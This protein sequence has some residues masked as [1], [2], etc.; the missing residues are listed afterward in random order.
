MKTLLFTS[1][2]RNNEKYIP[3]MFK[4]FDMIKKDLGDKYNINI[5][6]YTN[7]NKDSTEDLLNSRKGSDFEVIVKD[8]DNS[9]SNSIREKVSRLYYLREDLLKEIKKRE[10]DYLFMF[11]SDIYFNT[12]I[13]KEMIKV[14]DNTD[15]EAVTTNTLGQNFSLYYD[16]F[17]L[18]DENGKKINLDN[19][20]DVIKFHKKCFDEEII[21]VKSAFGGLFLTKYNTMNEK[22]L[23]YTKNLKIDK[24]VCEHIPFNKN[25]NL[26]FATN[27]NP[28]RLKLD[29]D[30]KHKQA[31]N[32]IKNN[33]SDNRNL[34]KDT[35]ILTLEILFLLLVFYGI[36][37]TKN[38]Y[39]IIFI[40]IL[41]L[42]IVN[43][44]EEIF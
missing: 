7:N 20:A 42:L 12:S 43:N 32:I 36:Y 13:I 28:I 39:L 6:V 27:I 21:N 17:S 9:Y 30:Y 1:L 23:S 37:K 19:K 5:L 31:Y 14:I 18:I 40:P 10:Y 24:N 35:G 33:K 29:Y 8:I 2:L 38:Y 22:D 15:Y 11:D 3:Y 41:V 26:A 4:I 16:F 44:F 25:F 34:Q